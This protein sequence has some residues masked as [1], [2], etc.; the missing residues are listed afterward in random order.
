M[1]CSK[2]NWIKQIVFAVFNVCVC[3]CVCVRARAC[4]EGGRDWERQR[5]REIFPSQTGA[6]N[7]Y[8]IGVKHTRAQS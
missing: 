4:V 6:K 1:D 7:I 2:I 5:R 3:V 8:S